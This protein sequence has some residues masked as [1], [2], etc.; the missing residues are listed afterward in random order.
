MGLSRA[1]GRSINTSD[2]CGIDCL[3]PEWRDLRLL[4]LRERGAELETVVE[5]DHTLIFSARRLAANGKA[6]PQR[7]PPP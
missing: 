4:S 3:Y 5:N 6:G 2:R 7:G 1:W